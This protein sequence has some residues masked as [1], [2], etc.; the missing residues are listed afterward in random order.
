L[1]PPLG[2]AP[3]REIALL[4]FLLLVFLAPLAIYCL[5]LAM[6][7]RRPL[8]VMV[9]GVWDC[10][11]LIFAASGFLLVIAPVLINTLYAKTL[12]LQ[13]L[14]P[15]EF[16]DI[17]LEYWIRTLLYYVVLI[18]G[19]V[20]LLWW[21]STKTVI[22]N[23]DA[24]RFNAVLDQ[25]LARL[26]LEAS[27]SGNQLLLTRAAVVETNIVDSNLMANDQA[28][29]IIHRAAG[30]PFPEALLV[31]EPFAALGNI[32]L[33]WSPGAVAVRDEVERELERNLIGARF[34]ENPAG[35]WF[36]G[37]AAALLSLIFVIVLVMVLSVLLPPPKK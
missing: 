25:T 3:V 36:L 7:N 10:V 28:M 20:L 29:E 21:R 34:F 13:P 19:I 17:W 23:V 33:H 32:T 31:V 6:L 30:S 24:D 4:F 16:Y 12:G 14:D 26:G 35:T 2:F 18:V 11:G 37:I 9:R 5:L 22:Y 8:P 27:R 15:G 1:P